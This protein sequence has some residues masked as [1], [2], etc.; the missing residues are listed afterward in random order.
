MIDLSTR[1]L[2]AMIALD[3]VRHFSLAAERC[4]VTQSALSQTISKLEAD[5]NLR[6]VDRDRRR[7]MLTPEGERFV[8]TARRVMA[9]LEEISIDLRDRSE[10]RKGRVVVTAQPSLAAHWLP[11]IIAAYQAR[12]PGV[13]FGLHDALP[14]KALEQIRQRQADL[15]LTA[16]GPG[17]AGLQHR[18]LFRDP[19]VLVCPCA[20]PLARRKSVSIAN[21]EG[22]R[23]IRLIRG[24]SIAQHLEQALRE[25]RFV[26]TGLEV[27]QVATLAGLVANGLGISIVPVCALAYFDPD[28]VAAV[29]VKGNDLSR[30]IYLV[31]PAGAQL[32]SAAESFVQMLK[33][34]EARMGFG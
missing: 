28:R 7:V 8:A 4:H 13:Q 33:P 21:L 23:F 27:E 31:W 11:P 18:L 1:V 29:P 17:L 6:L 25:A 26:D 3:E 22:Q 15:A 30:P 14:E 5:V 16:R 34:P 12:Y 19:F 20:H 24:G 9:E 32:S 2:R 10:L